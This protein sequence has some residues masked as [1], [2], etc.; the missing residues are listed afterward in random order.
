MQSNRRKIARLS[1]QA[2]RR[3]QRARSSLPMLLWALWTIAVAATGYLSWHA[4]MVAQRPLNT[5]GLVI[6]CVMVG[7]VGLV[8][9]TK[10]QMWLEPWRF[11]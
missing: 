1:K 3:Q 7:A 5:L 10:L 4:D 2:M 8:V 11:S 6:N 9:L